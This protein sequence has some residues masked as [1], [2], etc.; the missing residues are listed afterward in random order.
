VVIKKSPHP[1]SYFIFDCKISMRPFEETSGHHLKGLKVP[2]PF[3][4]RLLA[5]TSLKDFYSVDFEIISL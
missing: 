3:Q 1:Y 4:T 2:L 5:V